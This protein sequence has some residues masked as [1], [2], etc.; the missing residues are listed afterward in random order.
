VN[1]GAVKI[2]TSRPTVAALALAGT[3]VLGLA[4][5]ALADTPSFSAPQIYPFSFAPTRAVA[6]DVNNDGRADLVIANAAT[7]PTAGVLGVYVS[8]PEGTMDRQPD[9]AVGHGEDFG[10][11][12]A[13]LNRDGKV[14]LVSANDSGSDGPNTI[15]VIRGN[16]NGTFQP[17]LDFPTGVNPR[18]VAIADLNGDGIRDIVTANMDDGSVSV[19]R[20]NGDG[21]FQPKNDFPAGPKAQGVA[22]GDMNGDGILDLVVAN[23]GGV[24]ILAG[25]GNLQFA[26]K[27]D[28]PTG[29]A[30]SVALGDLNGDGKLDVVV[31]NP[32]TDSVAVL[33]GVGNG[34]LRGAVNY[35]TQTGPNTSPSYVA[36]GDLNGDRAL[37][38]AVSNYDQSPDGIGAAQVSVIPGTGDGTFGQTVGVPVGGG[39][40]G[41]ALGDF[42]ADGRPDM[43]M[44]EWRT[45][46]TR[47]VLNTTRFPTAAGGGGAPAAGAAAAVTPPSGGA[48]AAP[49]R[50]GGPA[51]AASPITLKKA[52]LTGRYRSSRLTRG[53]LALSGTSRAAVTAQVTLQRLHGVPAGA[54]AAGVSARV[55]IRKGAFKVTVRIKANLLPGSYRLR[56]ITKGTADVRRTVSLAGPPEG[57]V[58][59]AYASAI[60]GGPPLSRLRGSPTAA[61]ARFVF[62]TRP[63][64]GT[65]TVVWYPPKG[66]KPVVVDKTKVGTIDAVVK[67]GSALPK[68]V[69]RVVL[70]VGSAEVKAIRVPVG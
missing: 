28:F 46:T 64:K 55:K 3:A 20:G 36:I 51:A 5:P 17:R 8:R 18:D 31:T 44:A 58:V 4:V 35:A 42:N 41:I 47:V 50:S 39:L 24:S 33:M 14:D 21:T 2:S 37:D 56:I 27:T 52:T 38:I 63:K 30:G 45:G 23:A 65:V 68:G 10:L 19:L 60:L 53:T 29:V 67:S 7:E 61:F 34:L 40:Y 1:D 70:R 25:L 26:P 48:V 69:W 32:D 22:I 66:G 12:A 11:A 43:G 54:S 59:R 9:T 57:V 49:T 6:P 62:V 15:S 16:G 13:D